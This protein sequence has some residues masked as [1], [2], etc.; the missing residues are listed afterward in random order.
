VDIIKMLE[1]WV[2]TIMQVVGANFKFGQDCNN[3]GI[4]DDSSGKELYHLQF[5]LQVARTEIFG[6]TLIIHLYTL[7]HVIPKYRML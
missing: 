2:V 3:P 1:L 7:T 5:S 4:L 6:Y